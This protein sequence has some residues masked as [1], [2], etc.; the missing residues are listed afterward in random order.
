MNLELK[1]TSSL[2]VEINMAVRVPVS[3]LAGGD[4]S[5]LSPRE[6]QDIVD[7]ACAK[8]MPQLST[9]FSAI[10]SQ[11]HTTVHQ[12]CTESIRRHT[13]HAAAACTRRSPRQTI[14]TATNNGGMR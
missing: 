7:E 14:R 9:L 5:H 12:S 2:G 6:N 4:G 8:A 11:V 3:M 10:L 1:Y 13:N